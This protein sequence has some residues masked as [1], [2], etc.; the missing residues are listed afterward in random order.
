MHCIPD[1]IEDYILQVMDE[2]DWP[3]LQARFGVALSQ[4]IAQATLEAILGDAICYHAIMLR[5]SLWTKPAKLT[6]DG[7]PQLEV[8]EEDVGE[9]P[10]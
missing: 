3:K 6:G 4:R 2:I 8:M 9:N 5:P 1:D 10:D 7:P